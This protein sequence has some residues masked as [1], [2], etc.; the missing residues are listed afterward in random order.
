MSAPLPPV[1][2]LVRPQLGENIGKTARAMGNFGLREL[3]LVAPRDG[4]PNPAA[5]PAAAGADRLLDEARLFDT[6]EEA[7]SDLTGVLAATV[8]PRHLVKK[9]LDPQTAVDWLDATMRAGDG[10][11]GVMFGP[12]RS[13][14]DNDE[15]ALADAILTIPVDPAFASLNLAQAVLVLAYEWRKRILGG[16]LPPRLRSAERLPAPRGDYLGLFA[17]LEQ[18]LDARGHFPSSGRKPVQIR[19][20]RSL[21]LNARFSAQEIRTLRGVIKTLARPVR[22]QC[23]GND[24]KT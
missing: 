14:L 8:R 18:A 20:L 19:A 10:P 2:I 3:R 21:L 16:E 15:T 6:V 13:G 22:A 7:I 23:E 24:Q 9:V 4:W 17:Q 1:V 5:G 12:E 11:A